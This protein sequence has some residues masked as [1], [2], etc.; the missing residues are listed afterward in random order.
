MEYERHR[1]HRRRSEMIATDNNEM[2]ATDNDGHRLTITSFAV[3]PHP[4]QSVSSAPAPR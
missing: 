1:Y 2:I 3:Y 4:F